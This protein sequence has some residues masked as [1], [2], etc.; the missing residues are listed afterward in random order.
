MVRRLRRAGAIVVGTTNVAFML[1]DF[2][3]TANQ[4][5]GVT[6]RGIWRVLRAARPAVAAAAVAAGMS[7][8]I[9]AQTWWGRSGFRPASV[10]SMA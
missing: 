6:I 10:G 3:Q 7:S 9:T 8:S 2:A 5:Y 1:G 4:L